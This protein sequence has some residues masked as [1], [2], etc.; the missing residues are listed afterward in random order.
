MVAKFYGK[1]IPINHLRTICGTHREGTTLASL[2]QA[3]DD[4][5][6][7]SLVI[8]IGI[9][10]LEQFSLPCVLFVNDSHFVVLYKISGRRYKVADP[11][12]G[13]IILSRQDLEEMWTNSHA[14][15][16]V[17]LL[18]EPTA[19][20]VE[21]VYKTHEKDF[22]PL[23]YFNRLVTKY[24]KYLLVVVGGI[25]ITAI[26]N[27]LFP[28]L[29]QLIVDVGIA[30]QNFKIIY[31]ILFGQVT[32]FL[33]RVTIDA[34]RTWIVIHLSAHIYIASLSD[35]LVK[36]MGLPF[37][38][39][40]TTH[41][42]DI[43]GRITE[44]NRIENFVTG[45]AIN[46]IFS[47]LTILCLTAVLIYYNFYI[48]LLFIAGSLLYVLYSSYFFNRR[49]R[50]DDDQF[51]IRS[52]QNSLLV[53]MLG[54][55]K[56]IKL[57]VAQRYILD[58][59]TKI[60]L[61]LLD[62]NI[63]KTETNQFHDIG[64]GLI[65]EVKNISITVMA[66]SL[67]IDGELTLGMMLA[68]QYMI[69]QMNQ[70]LNTIVMFRNELQMY[71][72]SSERIRE[73]YELEDE[74]NTIP[75]HASKLTVNGSIKFENVGFSYS[76]K[77]SFVLKDLDFT[78][79]QGKITAIV[80]KSGSGKTT[81][82]KLLTKLYSPLIGKILIDGKNLE[83]CN[84][85]QWRSVVGVVM[86][87]GFLFEGTIA[88]NI[89]LSDHFDPDDQL[90]SSVT[91]IA[92]I[93][94]FITSLPRNLRTNIGSDGI[95]L[96]QG[97]KQRILIARALYKEPLL[98][99]LDEPTSALDSENENTIMANLLQNPQSSTIIIIAHRL[100]TI[101]SADQILV[102]D[103]GR[104]VESGSHNVLVRNRGFYYNLIESQLVL[105]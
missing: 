31:L 27:L 51:K 3:A 45:M 61:R 29:T 60:Q 94:D 70:P 15:K 82:V 8:E 9:E 20:L 92:N 71:R 5:G 100:S 86:Q 88:K 38:F 101:R 30:Q 81:L 63:S 90:L 59:W 74:E 19:R 69:G 34:V 41:F 28:L 50:I 52:D 21:A 99:I 75:N 4:L 46:I 104:I 54:G 25:L 57:S 17:C 49:K 16:G 43:F 39:F 14:N 84:H 79:P 80:G 7:T 13:K 56:D 91:R 47:L 87:D 95:A 18:L 96:S 53:Q 83:E 22:A 97:Q 35:F 24:R 102:L 98:L 48:S 89:T 12:K 68:V 64:G 6:F 76:N 67:V 85:S 105:G 32:L 44:H 58:D 93:G 23:Q 10:K 42:G 65:N 2:K 72:I 66:A 103:N 78:I 62:N 26:L 55:I 1:E 77:T 36:L 37:S 11:A 40:E 33:G 73:V